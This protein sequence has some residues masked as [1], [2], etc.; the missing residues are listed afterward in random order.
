MKLYP[1]NMGSKSAKALADSLGI[2][3]LRHEGGRVKANHTVINWGASKINREIEG[4]IINDPKAVSNAV[5][6]L[7]TLMMLQDNIPVPMWTVNK[8]TA[9]D[10]LVDGKTVVVVRHKLN[11]HSGEG[12]ELIKGEDEKLPDAPLYTKYIPKKDEYRIHVMMDQ[13]F[14]TQRK[15]RRLD[16]PAEDVNWKIRNHQNGFIFAHQ[17]LEMPNQHQAEPIAVAAVATLGLDFGAVDMIWSTRDT[18]HVLEVNTA[19]GL[20]GETLFQYT[21]AFQELIV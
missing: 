8:E 12:I 10:W 16:I 7:N 13:V 11:G 18:W 5:S 17:N 6:K 9:Q 20:E 21:Q 4:V 1:Y 2:K 14:F 15:A 3:R 19:C